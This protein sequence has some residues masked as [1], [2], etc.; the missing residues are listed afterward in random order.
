EENAIDG[1]K[2]ESLAVNLGHPGAKR[3]GAA[4]R[5]YWC[6]RRGFVLW[7]MLRA[8]EDFA[9]TG[10]EKTRRFWQSANHFQQPDR[11]KRCNPAGFLDFLK[12]LADVALAGKVI[13]FI[14]CGFFQRLAHGF[15]V[16]KIGR[17]KKQAFLMNALIAD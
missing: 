12:A 10:V 8:A 11:A 7:R 14:R 2:P 15:G 1:E 9:G 16:F 17:I 4:V 13:D 5:R 3:L 6:D